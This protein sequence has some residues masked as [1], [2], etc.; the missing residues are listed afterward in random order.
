[1]CGCHRFKAYSVFHELQEDLRGLGLGLGLASRL[2]AC[3]MNS[4]KTSEVG[5]GGN[6]ALSSD[7][8]TAILM[9][10]SHLSREEGHSLP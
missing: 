6:E 9:P 1:M 7:I 3:S 8:V 4:K 10:D 2:T 5:Q